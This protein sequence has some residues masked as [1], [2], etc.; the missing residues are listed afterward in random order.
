MHSDFL[1]QIRLFFHPKKKSFFDI[2]QI[3]GFFPRNIELYEEALAHK[4]VHGFEEFRGLQTNERLEFL[5]D[6]VLSSIITD[7]IFHNYP[8]RNEGFL[9]QTRSF[10]VNREQ[11]DHLAIEIGLDRLVVAASMLKIGARKNHLSGNALEAIIGAIYLDRG[12]YYARR[13]IEKKILKTCI[14]IDSL[15]CKNINFKSQL[16]QWCQRNHISL[17]YRITELPPDEH[18]NPVFSCEVYV[19]NKLSGNGKGLSKRAAHQ[20]A[21]RMA[22]LEIRK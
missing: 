7:I 8:E 12:Y 17:E 5:G 4:S 14:D 13:F 19:E 9:S 16:L 20:A 3:L 21:A 15:A 2:K 10:I 1:E 22:L 11:L 6:A 18:H